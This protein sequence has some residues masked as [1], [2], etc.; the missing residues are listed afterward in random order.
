ME[1]G[2]VPAL[3]QV[4]VLRRQLFDGAV[5]HGPPVLLRTEQQR[6][7]LLELFLVLVAAGIAEIA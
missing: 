6:V 7:Q 4:D 5:F 2:A 3:G 1:Y